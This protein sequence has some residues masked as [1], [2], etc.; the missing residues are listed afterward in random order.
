M[1]PATSPARRIV[2]P[3]RWS[4]RAA[5]SAPSPGAFEIPRPDSPRRRLGSVEALRGAAALLLVVFHVQAM[6]GTALSGPAGRFVE[7]FASGV[8]LFYAISAFSLLIG[9]HGMLEQPGGLRKF[10]VR[11]FFRIA[12]LY[13]AM[14]LFYLLLAVC[15]FHRSIDWSEVLLDATFLFALVPGKHEGIVWASWSIGVEWIFYALFPLVLVLTP[16]KRSALALL[17][18]SLLISRGF[19]LW[20]ATAGGD[21]TTFAYMGF[22]NHLVFFAAGVLAFRWVEGSLARQSADAAPPNRPARWVPLLLVVGLLAAGQWTPLANVLGWLRLGTHAKALIWFIL[23][24]G[25]A[26]GLPLIDNRWLRLAGRWSFGIY[27]LNPPVVHALHRAG[28]YAAI[29]HVVASADLAFC[30]AAALTIAVVAAAAGVAHAAI[31]S[32][33]IRLGD[34]VLGR[35]GRAA[36]V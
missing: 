27:L 2:P 11:R 25:A 9:Y 16:G 6:S 4:R 22:P 20:M 18:A 3:P 36:P 17:A 8:P 28:V 7:S 29:R 19:M 33:G 5:S 14:L 35:F 1:P 12:P 26:N 31:E 15:R 30:C 34:R 23:L 32:P 21:Q 24:V 13:Y 10:Y